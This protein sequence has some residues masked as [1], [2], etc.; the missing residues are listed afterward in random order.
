MPHEAVDEPADGKG[1]LCDAEPPAEGRG[2][3]E[4]RHEPFVEGA[5]HGGHEGHQNQMKQADGHPTQPVAD[6]P[7]DP[8]RAPEGDGLGLHRSVGGDWHCRPHLRSRKRSQKMLD[9]P[10]HNFLD[11]S[12]TQWAL[13][14]TMSFPAS[15]VS[16]PEWPM[17]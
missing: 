9:T 7:G 3:A 16:L 10:C 1:R 8:C 4:G 2:E 12:P 5:R 17:P 15:H 14:L 11:L 13:P 6:A